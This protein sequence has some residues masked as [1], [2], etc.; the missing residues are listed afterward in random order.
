MCFTE[1]GKEEKMQIIYNPHTDLLYIR[2][3]E[4][5]QD[6]INHRI[7]DEIVL[8]IGKN[9]KIVGIEILDASKNLDLN[10]VLPVKF[11]LE[12]ES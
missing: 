5:R 11:S 2:I 10:N 12:K 3:D 4:K 9:S 1:N 7:S 8:D 6:V